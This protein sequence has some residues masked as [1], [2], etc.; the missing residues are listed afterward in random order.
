MMNSE[1]IKR[2]IHHFNYFYLKLFQ[3]YTAIFY[4]LKKKIKGFT[5]Q[6]GLRAEL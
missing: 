1:F 3:L 5:L 4:F 6:S 2:K